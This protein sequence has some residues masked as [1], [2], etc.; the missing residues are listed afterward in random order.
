MKITTTSKATPVKPQSRIEVIDVIRGFALFGVLAMNMSGYSGSFENME[1]WSKLD[2]WIN[3][4]AHFFIEAKFYSIFSFLFGLG[5]AMQMLRAEERGVKFIPVYVRRLLVLL[6]IGM[7]HATFL[8]TGDILFLYACCGFLLLLF[9]KF[10]PKVILLAAFV[11]LLHPLLISLP[12]IST[13]YTEAFS[14][15]TESLRQ[16]IGSGQHLYTTG[17]YFQVTALRFWEVMAMYMVIMFAFGNVFVM[18]LFG[19]YAGKRKFFQNL[20][21]HLPFIRRLM[22]G[23]LVLGVLLNGLYVFFIIN[24]DTV[25]ENFIALSRRGIRTFAAPTLC[26]FYITAITLLYQKESWRQRLHF[27]APLGRMALTNYLMHSLV[28]TT[29]FY[30]YGLG[31]HGELTPTADL[32]LTVLLYTFQIRFSAWWLE[33]YRFG[34]AE[35]AWRSLTYGQL[36]PMRVDVAGQEAV[37]SRRSVALVTGAI[38]LCLGFILWQGW[39]ALPQEEQSEVSGGLVGPTA[40]L[41]IPTPRPTATPT[42]ISTPAVEPVVR[43]PQPAAARADLWELALAFDEELA[44]AEIETL[45]GPPYLGRL[46]GSPGGRAAGEYLAQ[47]FAE[48]GL[49]PAGLD[50]T[51]FQSFPLVYTQ[52]AAMPWLTITDPIGAEHTYHLRQDFSPLVT[53]YMGG[54]QAEGPVIWANNC[55]HN[56]FDYANVVDKVVLCWD[57]LWRK[58]EQD[59]GRNALEHGAAGLLLLSDPLEETSPFDRIAPNREVWVS[60]PIPT[61][62][63]SA[64]VAEDLLS[65]A[66]FTLDDLTI[67]LNPFPLS[68]TVR[69][70][71]PLSTDE[72]AQ[73]RNVLGVLPGRDPEYAG[74]LVILGAHYDHV[75]EDPDGTVWPGANDNASGV[76]VLLETARA[77]HAQGYVPRRTVLFAAWDAEEIGLD[78]SRY[79]VAH[80]QYPLTTTTTIAMLQLDMV[81][82]GEDI[83]YLDGPNNQYTQKIKTI[84]GALGI[85]TTLTRAGGSDHAPFMEAGVPANLLIWTGPKETPATAHY[86]RPLDTPAIIEPDKMAAIG[87]LTNLTLLALVEGEPAIFD[88]LE[89]R[90][91]AVNEGDLAAFLQSGTSARQ[92]SDTAWFTDVQKLT[93][94]Q[95]EL[96]ASSLRVV[97]RVA[98]ATVQL[99]LTY[100]EKLRPAD[101]AASL[102]VRFV[103]Q[104]G[105]WRWDGPALVWQKPHDGLAVASPPESTV[106]AL[107]L[108]QLAKQQY[109]PIAAQLDLPPQSQASLVLYPNHQALRADT[110]LTLPANTGSFID[111]RPG[112]D[113]VLKLVLTPE[114]SQ[115]QRFTDTLVQLALVEAGVPEAAAPWLWQ[116]LPMAYHAQTN[117]LAAQ[118]AYLPMLYEAL[119][120]APGGGHAA[121]LAPDSLSWAA[122]EYLRE[123]AGWD[124]IGQLVG[125]LGQGTTL[126]EALTQLLGVNAAGFEAMWRVTWQN[127]LQEIQEQMNALLTARQQAMLAGDEGA[128][129]QTVDPAD[130]TFMAEERSWF[131]EMNT[132]SVEYF[133]ISGQPMA[134]LDDGG[135]WVQIKMKYK[136]ASNHTD[137]SISLPIKLTRADAGY[138]WAG[139][140]FETITTEHLIIHYPA[141]QAQLAQALLA[142]AESVYAQ[143]IADL[144]IETHEPLTLKLY[145]DPTAFYASLAFSGPMWSDTWTAP[146]QSIKLLVNSANAGDYRRV[147]ARELTRA[148]LSPASNQFDWLREGLAIYESGRINRADARDITIQNGPLVI[149]TNLKNQLFTVAEPPTITGLSQQEVEPIY[150]Q[151]WDMARYLVETYGQTRL[152]A[153]LRRL[154]QGKTLASAFPAVYGLSL[155]EFENVWRDSVG[156]G[157]VGPEWVDLAQQFA[158]AAV[159]THLTALTRPEYAG[160]APGSAGEAAAA[161][162]IAKQ[163]ATYGLTPAGADGS[164]LQPF[165]ITYSVLTSVPRLWALNQAGQPVAALGHRQ[166][167]VVIQDEAAGGGRVEAD[168]VWIRGQDYGP[169]RLAGKVAL[170]TLTGPLAEEIAAAI[171]HDAGGLILVGT[172]QEKE[173]WPK[174]LVTPESDTPEKTIPVVELTP[175]AFKRLIETAGHSVT[176]LN[177]SPPVMPLA[178]RVL[179][180]VPLQTQTLTSANVLGLLPGSDLALQDEVIILGAHYDHVGDDPDERVCLA[181]GECIDLPGL[182]Y[183]G[184]NEDAAA[185]G[186]LLEIARLWQEKNYRPART[187]LFAAWGS[188]ELDQAGSRY[189]VAQPTLPL[190]D[191]VAMFQLEAVGGGRGF[192]LQAHGDKEEVML[193]FTVEAAARQVEARLNSFPKSAP[194]SD[195]ESFRRKGIPA[196]LISWEKAATENLP[197][198]YDDEIDLLR[199]GQTGRTVTLALMMLAQ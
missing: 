158:V 69:L 45:T 101:Q 189:Y 94:P 110:S 28:L 4:L 164:F 183:T 70:A 177:T 198:P 196:M 37:P 120:A 67:A 151:S 53:R 102:P 135:L 35:W 60:Q 92:A 36:Q 123:Q 17:T 14:R 122:V 98:T 159:E 108:S 136:L 105:G 128:F 62:R 81:G 185:V 18:F 38:T 75:G 5:M 30:G 84:A 142:E 168:V 107:E 175:A 42:P 162:Y 1:N 65:G 48:Y 22:W 118:E 44:L 31:I 155:A 89:A 93:W 24:P 184:A 66:G 83:L 111:H 172:R 131:N 132:R 6:L 160:R 68:T 179:L 21:E 2:E 80:P 181:T 117:P 170:R 106:E 76:A 146:G 149:R 16:T 166:D 58:R 3:W 26:F 15:A 23:T 182:A 161:T 34:P 63:I 11:T 119:V 74:E 109:A 43:Q 54:G 7:A 188:Q 20:P 10:S 134:L 180:E 150:A 50:G 49:R 100:T 173:L 61:L 178:L 143:I 95:L 129:L 147:L 127:R 56:D 112:Q 167:F 140:L 195:H 197:L 8:W 52:L 174:K 157:H 163:F 85:S 12:G 41:A 116:G 55:A 121:P 114:L 73:G 103:H 9:R 82:A 96:E 145:A 47:R 59:V 193:R 77:W 19:L 86:H 97:G 27:L 137:S 191:T 141:E 64:D 87:R 154:Q 125:A 13:A 71:V 144:Q 79:Y 152:P 186:V 40:T 176:D 91:K 78:G 148:L 165:P 187:V 25:A 99:K 171:A 192:R 33:R 124:G 57:R 194:P 29:I 32:I 138:R 133:E 104:N 88:L 51:F 46:A 199:L 72:T 139:P 169:I 126:D 190:T 90:Q 156:Q 153:L 39:R 130:P 113:P 115:T